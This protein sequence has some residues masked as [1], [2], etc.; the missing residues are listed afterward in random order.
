MRSACIALLI[1]TAVSACA[2]AQAP[3]SKA[4]EDSEPDVTQQ[5]GAILAR[6]TQG[7]L[8]A[9]PLTENARTALDAAHTRQIT[10]TLR[11]CRELNTLELLS[12]TTK[13]EERQY[14]YRASCG[15][16]PLLVEIYFGKGARISHLDV[17]P[18]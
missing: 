12:R 3:A 2:N 10:E 17:R 18:Q 8:A 4:I 15:G 16:K 14:L 6:A 9:E 11:S 7:A 5:V 1:A 13:G